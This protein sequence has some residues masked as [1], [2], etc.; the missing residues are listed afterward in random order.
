M[1]YTQQFNAGCRYASLTEVGNLLLAFIFK[2][3]QVKSLLGLGPKNKMPK[4]LT[5]VYAFLNAKAEETEGAAVDRLIEALAV[6]P[7]NGV[8]KEDGSDPDVIKLLTSITKTLEPVAPTIEARIRDK[9]DKRSTN[10]RF[11]ELV[12]IIQSI[13]PITAPVAKQSPAFTKELDTFSI[14]GLQDL[15][16]SDLEGTYS[17]YATAPTLLQ[18][19]LTKLEYSALNKLFEKTL[20]QVGIPG[21]EPRESDDAYRTRKRNL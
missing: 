18:L 15:A 16:A 21:Q 12:T 5:L 8:Q 14:P 13:N 6:Y 3:P 10:Q 19:V 7:S 20:D 17:G 2:Q 11:K 4:V 9:A 1:G